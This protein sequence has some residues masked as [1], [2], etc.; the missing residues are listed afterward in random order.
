MAA[1][2]FIAGITGCVIAFHEELDTALNPDLFLTSS[3][4]AYLSGGE[5]AKRVKAQRPGTQIYMIT[6]NV[7]V[8]HTS[9]L[10]VSAH[11]PGVFF[12]QAFVDPVTGKIQGE[13]PWGEASLSPRQ[14]IPFL[15]KLH[16]SLAIPGMWGIWLMGG[17]ALIWTFDCFTAFLHTLP[18]RRPIWPKWKQ[19]WTFKRGAKP[20]RFIMDLHRASAL[21]LWLLLF[22]LAT[23]SVGLNLQTEIFRPLIASVWDLKPGFN[24]WMEKSPV[25]SGKN[26]IGYGKAMNI[27]RANLPKDVTFA[28]AMQYGGLYDITYGLNGANGIDGW[29]GSQLYLNAYTGKIL[30]NEHPWE[31]TPGD[32]I[33]AL[34]F[35][36]HSGR[37]FGL[38]GRISMSLMGLVVAMLSLT[39]VLIWLKKRRSKISI[40]RN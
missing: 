12:D 32:K 38:A 24:Q 14:I 19:A 13:R 6:E 20:F 9:L 37:V 29:G 30:T 11:E 8:G 2:L 3:R 4:G 25:Q 17:I 23:T 22:I 39:G 36:M 1:F 34:Q 31:G 18:A 28:Y 15:Y 26:M 5:L 40:N 35:P 33:M 16:Y 21:W 27:A 10:R 7:P